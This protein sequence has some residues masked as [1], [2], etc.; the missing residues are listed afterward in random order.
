MRALWASELL[1]VW[2][3]GFSQPP[4]ERALALLGLGFPETSRD[5]LAALSI[6][7][8]DEKLLR[9]REGLWGPRMAA[10]AVCPN[11]RQKLELSLDSGE[12]LSSEQVQDATRQIT[13]G[14][15]AL[16]I[17]E[18]KVTFRLPTSQDLIAME[19][20]DPGGCRSLLLDRCLLSAR[21][22]DASMNSGE[23]PPD[24]AED[25]VQRM[26]EADPL[27]DIQ[28]DLTC[29]SCEHHWHA[30]F[31]IV[32]FLWTEIEVWAWRML[33]DVHTLARAYGW[34]ERDILAL[35]PARR[36]LYLEMVGA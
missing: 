29:P 9:L 1:E 25:I 11:C 13:P 20:A 2:E 6:G 36:Q 14:E 27:A 30:V 7:S 23:L 18:F 21:H 12:M 5:G 35:S 24:V 3:A 15:I 26:V 22:G 17:G 8:R 4:T 33:R 34:A 31:D 32:S 10:V 28:L 19:Q 16:S